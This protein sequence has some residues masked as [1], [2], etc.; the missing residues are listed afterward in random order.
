LDGCVVPP[1]L[2]ANISN[3]E[4]II[5]KIT[6]II[7]ITTATTNPPAEISV[8]NPLTAFSFFSQQF[9][10]YISLIFRFAYQYHYVPDF[11]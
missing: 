4:D 7:K 3:G 5:S 6:A 10:R 8:I 11:A 9:F 2:P 1:V